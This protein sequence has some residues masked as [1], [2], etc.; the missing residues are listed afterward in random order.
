MF[1]TKT[2]NEKRYKK[3][4]KKEREKK[5]EIPETKN[6]AVTYNESKNNQISIDNFSQKGFKF[7]YAPHIFDINV[8]LPEQIQSPKV[9]GAFI[10]FRIHSGK[11]NIGS[12]SISRI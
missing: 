3:N 7:F 11:R 4:R 1:K 8:I 6:R 2:R 10:K 5:I 9:G 12:H